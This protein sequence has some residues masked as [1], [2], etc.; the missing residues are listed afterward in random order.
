MVLLLTIDS[1]LLTSRILLIGRKARGWLCVLGETWVINAD[2]GIGAVLS[3]PLNDFLEERIFWS[4][5]EEVAV[6]ISC[7][8]IK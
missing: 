4:S 6:E 3:P 8:S 5:R 1:S 2:G 7:L